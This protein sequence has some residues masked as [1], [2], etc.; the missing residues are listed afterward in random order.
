MELCGV[1][2]NAI[3]G[4]VQFYQRC[5]RLC[6]PVLCDHLL[7]LWCHLRKMLSE[8]IVDEAI[9]SACSLDESVASSVL[10]EL[11]VVPWGIAVSSKHNT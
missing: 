7:L 2:P 6:D 3:A 10:E 5:L 11:G 1:E 4:F 9:T 8:K